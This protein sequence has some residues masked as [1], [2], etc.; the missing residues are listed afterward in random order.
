MAL[1]FRG[2]ARK[3]FL[4]L[5]TRRR[6]EKD[7][8]G[9]AAELREF[10]RRLVGGSRRTPRRAG[11]LQRSRGEAAAAGAAARARKAARQRFARRISSVLTREMHSVRIGRGAGYP[12]R[13][14]AGGRSPVDCTAFRV[15][16]GGGLS[17]TQSARPSSGSRRSPFKS[18]GLRVDP[19]AGYP[20]PPAR[21][22]PMRR[23]RSPV[24]CT[25]LRVDW[26]G[27]IVRSGVRLAMLY[28]LPA[29]QARKRVGAGHLGGS[30]TL[31]TL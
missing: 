30:H 19:E 26:A 27:A 13:P 8:T 22:P 18:T 2:K 20:H 24:E 5:L 7:C 17:T 31:K 23:R 3:F 14:A 16:S 1:F 9:F 11:A 10:C 12:Q 4:I 28:L 21:F 25:G 6:S 29:R 15:S